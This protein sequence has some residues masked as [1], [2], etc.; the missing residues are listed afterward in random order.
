[1]P[2]NTNVFIIRHGEKPESGPGLTI[3][4]QARAQAYAVF[5]QHYVIG[6]SVIT[7]DYLF[8]AA[9]TPESHRSRLTLEPLAHALGKKIDCEHRDH[10]EIVEDILQDKEYN[11]AN[12]LICW[13][14]GDILA[15]SVDLG[16]DASVLPPASNW[17]A[18]WP[19][20]VFGW[21]LQISYD[22]HGKI[23]PSQTLCTNQR[24]M[25]G[26]HGQ[27]PPVLI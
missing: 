15:L 21:V 13:H 27:N 20:E 19:A 14:H 4:G 16:V 5:F 18:V 24:L 22:A 23:V 2:R 11:D 12:V 7:L 10:H 25:H 8:A 26:D 17:P 6:S 9:D 1:M 3:A